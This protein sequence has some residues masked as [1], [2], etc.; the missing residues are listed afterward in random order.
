MTISKKKI[1]VGVFG[2]RRGM[3]MINML[4]NHPDA[5]LVA[6]C[7]KAEYLQ[8]RCEKIAREADLNVTVYS[9]FDK[10]FNHDMDAVVL[11]NYANQHAPYAVKFL[12]S[13]RH[14]LSEVVP[15]QTLAEAV[16]LVEAVEKS[17]K[18]YSYA[19]NYCYFPATQEMKRLYKLGEI[20]EFMHGEGEYVHDCE[21][22][23][24]SITYGDKNHWRNN[25][26]S[27]FYCTH[28]IGP[29]LN[30]TGVRPVVVVGFETPNV[31]NMAAVGYKGGTSGMIIMQMSNGATAKSL[32]GNLKREPGSIWY[33]IYGK[34]GMMESDRWHE[35]IARINVFKEGSE[36]TPYEISYRP[37]PKVTTDLAKRIEGHGGSDFYTVH[38]FLEKILGRPDGEE[39]IDVYHALDMGIPGIIAYRSICNGNIPI[40]VPDFKNKSIREKYRNDNWCTDPN[41]AGEDVAPNCSFGSPDIPDSVYDRVKDIWVKSIKSS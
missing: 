2:A 9:D 16:T 18:I 14:V 10:F 30:I 8:K 3:T 35:R 17:G 12:L 31:E 11:A 21:S 13:G 37:K 25:K 26:Y 36:L 41:I 40:E 5:E 7:D 33:S 39:S 24:P 1:K 28:S 38:Y 32:H 20:G 4:I 34:K 19:E 15:V 22:I 6:I 27:T 23:W 29:I